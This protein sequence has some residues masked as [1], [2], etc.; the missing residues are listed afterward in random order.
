MDTDN[1]V[2]IKYILETYILHYICHLSDYN[3]AP[4]LES[5]LIKE[6]VKTEYNKS[7]LKYK[8]EINRIVSKITPY[9]KYDINYIY[10][11]IEEKNSLLEVY[12][13]KMIKELN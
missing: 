11:T 4:S 9:E 7:I 10:E 13:E 6:Q 5:Y 3:K 2:M 1:K 8:K 12:I